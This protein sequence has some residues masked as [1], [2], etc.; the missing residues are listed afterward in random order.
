MKIHK[1]NSKIQEIQK[2]VDEIPWEVWTC[3][4]DKYTQSRV[5]GE[6]ISFGDSDYKT[7]Q[8]MR[9]GIEWLVVQFGGNVEW[10][11]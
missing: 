6:H 8:E 3:F 1:A 9:K 5:S 2:S 11:D 4:W 10:K 7:L